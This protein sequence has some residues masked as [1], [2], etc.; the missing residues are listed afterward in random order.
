MIPVLRR[1]TESLTTLQHA[2][3][4]R[5]RPI[6]SALSKGIA[7]LPDEILALIFEYS[8]PP[9]EGTRQAVWLSHVSRR[10]RRIALS[11]CRL[12][13]TLHSNAKRKELKA[14]ASY[15]GKETDL[16]IVVRRPVGTVDTHEFLDI[17]TPMA[18]RWLTFTISCVLDDTDGDKLETVD[19][20]MRDV[21][22]RYQLVL[23][24]LREFRIRQCRSDIHTGMNSWAAERFLPSW[25]TPNL[26]IIH[27]D[28]YIPQTSP[29]YAFLDSFTT[30]ISLDT[31]DYPA[32]FGILLAFLGSEPTIKDV[33]LTVNILINILQ[34]LQLASVLC[35][36]LT[37]LCLHFSSVIFPAGTGELLE[38]L[39]RS[40]TMPNLA[41]FSASVEFRYDDLVDHDD[42]EEESGALH[43]LVRALL[44]DPNT[45]TSLTSLNINF[46]VAHTEA[47][48]D[49]EYHISEKNISI[50]LDRI[51]HVVTLSIKT[52]GQLRFSRQNNTGSEVESS[53]RE[54]RLHECEQVDEECLKGMIASLKDVGAWDKLKSFKM[55]HCFWD[56][57]DALKIIGAERLDGDMNVS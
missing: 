52:F 25:T 16:H 51:P 42:K 38:P 23:L 44:P 33:K 56:Y 14:L 5:L 55:E 15:S 34:P 3:G 47:T 53:L 26:N 40:L 17:C 6:S 22:R 37:S 21:F 4:N 39:I 50:P 54:L 43:D 28:E 30:S 45:H 41:S 27:C 7:P 9:G 57:N 1:L 18:S 19:G 29:S 2:F 8:S 24:R 49:W 10:F 13:T 46:R 12:W 32:Q 31:Q 11:A 35:A 20:A 36:S 48:K